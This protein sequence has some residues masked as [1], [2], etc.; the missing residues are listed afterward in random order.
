M[1]HFIILTLCLVL[2]SGISHGYTNDFV[3]SPQGKVMYVYR[4]DDE[5]LMTLLFENII[6]M[7]CS[8]ENLD[9][10]LCEEYVTQE[11]LTVDS[12]Y[13]I[14][15]SVVDSIS[16]HPLPNSYLPTTIEIDSSLAQYIVKIEDDEV[17]LK[18]DT[19][20]DLIPEHGEVL[21]S[22]GV[23][24]VCDNGFAG[25]VVEEIRENDIIRLDCEPV[26]V[27]DVFEVFYACLDDDS[28][29][30]T[31]STTDN[32]TPIPFDLN[33][34]D[35]GIVALNINEL[36]KDAKRDDLGKM[37]FG[38]GINRY[39]GVIHPKRCKFTPTIS[40]QRYKF[41]TIE[42]FLDI[43]MQIELNM[44]CSVGLEAGPSKLKKIFQEKDLLEGLGKKFDRINKF[45]ELFKKWPI[46]MYADFEPSLGI[47]SN[48]ILGLYGSLSI[49][50][51]DYVK[52]DL[53][54]FIGWNGSDTRNFIIYM[55]QQ[56]KDGNFKVIPE[57]RCKYAFGNVK[58]ECGLNI[59]LGLGILKN[60]GK[61]SGIQ[62]KDKG[63]DYDKKQ[64]LCKAGINAGLN[65]D[66]QVNVPIYLDGSS[67]GRRSLDEYEKYVETKA[68]GI[69]GGVELKLNVK[70][71]LENRIK[72]KLGNNISVGD[73]GN[74]EINLIE[75]HLDYSTWNVPLFGNGNFD[76]LTK[77]VSFELS[78]NLVY[79]H[80]VGVAVYDESLWEEIGDVT[81]EDNP[82]IYY[83]MTP[84][85]G[86]LLHP[87]NS[88]SEF[89][90]Q[91]PS[92][93]PFRKYSI[94]PIV[95][96]KIFTNICE[97][98]P[99]LCGPSIQVEVGV[100]LFTHSAEVN[101][102]DMTALLNGFVSD[103][104]ILYGIE[105]EVG[106]EFGMRSVPV[107]ERMKIP[108][109]IDS[110]GHV[111]A[112]VRNLERGIEYSCRIYLR[113]DDKY[114]YGDFKHFTIE[115]KEDP[116]N[117]EDLIDLGLSVKWRNCNL[118]AT[119]ENEYG[120]YYAWGETESKEKYSWNTYF[121]SPYTDTS[122]WKGCEINMDISGKEY[123]AATALLG[124]R[125]RMPTKDEMQELIDNCVWEWTQ[126]KD[127]HGFKVT[128]PNGNN[129]FLPA[130]GNKEDKDV[131][132]PGKYGGYWTSVPMSDNSKSMASNLYFY[133][134][135]SY[136]LFNLQW[137]NRYTG[138]S[139]RPVGE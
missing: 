62:T 19:P 130:A 32:Y 137:S 124:S 91:I 79:C 45:G 133:G 90:I 81:T 60:M 15:I 80:N 8:K 92:L 25:R 85:D 39:D 114:Y 82:T 127:T 97:P 71:D 48:M 31:R 128:G 106:M 1:K 113:I 132:N 88:Y 131:S 29:I 116:N 23:E 43:D 70:S 5:R 120:D 100:D 21:F 96:Q 98:V 119:V 38:I 115:P 78:K 87:E 125:Y 94:Y 74:I 47:G 4:N 44:D 104:D 51:R 121:D 118:G 42:G 46:Q 11:I 99:M 112:N 52:F 93:K 22:F 57:I 136:K 76:P 75:K 14:P 7:R 9:H 135:T 61:K 134:T 109:K 50:Y 107:S 2:F 34:M 16:F 73:R 26:G 68:Y 37:E 123:D 105:Y 18:G 40:M 108:A 66:I 55:G 65:S 56:I 126:L 86:Y 139:I 63:D 122:E 17:F 102:D 3:S 95:D 67:I 41:Y 33:F 27:E 101:E 110:K 138:R 72:L 24:G 129:I 36:L 83:H 35:S 117:P 10:Q 13:R 77:T 59:S 49:Q 64:W 30:E 58:G 54:D 28:L 69:G 12:L 53:C 111:E 6:E 89:K 84:Y 20:Q 103:I